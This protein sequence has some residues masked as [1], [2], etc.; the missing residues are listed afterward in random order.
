MASKFP[1]APRSQGSSFMKD[2]DRRRAVMLSAVL[3]LL[4]L[5]LLLWAVNPLELE[6]ESYVVIDVGLPALADESVQAAT[7]EQPAPASEEASVAAEQAGAPQQAQQ[8]APIPAQSLPQPQ[9]QATVPEPQPVEAQAEA[10]VA[11]AQA[12]PEPAAQSQVAEAQEVPAPQVEAAV[13]EAQAIEAQPQAQVAEAEPVPQPD[14]DVALPE[15][16]PVETLPQTEVAA[17]QNVP[18]PQV[19]AAVPEAQAIE[20]QPQIE[21]AEAQPLEAQPQVEVAEAQE[22]PEP[23]VETT[24]P[25]AQAVETQPQTEV[26]EA[27][28]VPAPQV[29][30]VVPETQAVE[31]Q[32]QVEVSQSDAPS[33]DSVTDSVVESA[34]GSEAAPVDSSDV[35]ESLA[36]SSQEV[37][38]PS[39]PE[40]SSSS[41]ADSLVPRAPTESANEASSDT[42]SDLTTESPT[43]SA[44]V[45]ELEQQGAATA[46]SGGQLDVDSQIDSSRLLA[47]P[48]GADADETRQSQVDPA[49]QEGNLG[50]AA[51]PDGSLT[52]TGVPAAPTPF[53]TTLERPLNVIL[54]NVRGYPQ[55]GLR[56]ASAVFEMPVEGG[57]TRL[58]SMYD[59]ATPSRVGPVR[60]ARDYFHSLSENMNG[61]MVHVGGSPSALAQIANSSTPTL[62]AFASGDL[63]SRDNARSA[64]YNLYSSGSA[65]RQALNRL[66]LN[67]SRVLSGTIFRPDD[68]ALPSSEISVRFSGSYSS[69]FRYSPELNLYRWVR[70]GQNASD[71]SGEAVFVDAVVVARV[72]ATPIPADP[73]GRLY[74]PMTGGEATLHLRGKAIPGRWSPQ[75]GFSFTSAQ[76]QAVN[77]A[78]FK[79]WVLFAPSYANVSVQ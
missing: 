9:A 71:A 1:P 18:E 40:S 48:E 11:A 8:E 29:E 53:S 14:V 10:S 17:A 22:L 19:E 58:M 50:A 5:L 35:S 70:N 54:D 13:A 56:E 36:E 32:P 30:A 49:A 34:T 44:A 46:P 61:V 45:D 43:E 25:E 38:E 33:D 28:N 12:I 65:L 6:R 41:L 57:L 27:Q 3:H 73:A 69:G 21:V 59:R 60:S 23:Q 42:V 2:P 79:Y 15:P 16:R 77:L 24:V 37:L 55:I 47:E 52:P 78:P 76:G 68:T 51:S 66:N 63:F 39:S 7:V 75:G 67:R 72:S 26:A 4:A 62:D 31:T 20:T 74:I 64:P